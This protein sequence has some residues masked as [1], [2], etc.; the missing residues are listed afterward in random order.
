[1]H[2]MK[3]KNGH[4]NW[5]HHLHRTVWKLR[6]KRKLWPRK[7]TTVIIIESLKCTYTYNSL[8][9]GFHLM[10]PITNL[11]RSTND[12]QMK[13]GNRERIQNGCETYLNIIKNS[14]FYI[15]MEVVGN[16]KCH[17]VSILQSSILIRTPYTVQNDA[18][19]NRVVTFHLG[20]IS[21]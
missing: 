11:I 21:R 14:L 6:M 8:C 17:I 19:W 15:I 2:E 9:F 18:W 3:W 12:N 4:L 5:L 1:M 10:R 13:I 7:F 16:S 20:L